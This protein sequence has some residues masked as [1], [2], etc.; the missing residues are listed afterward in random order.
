MGGS[1][2]I[3][4][5]VAGFVGILIG[6]WMGPDVDDARDEIVSRVDEV[7]GTLGRIDEKVATLGAP[8]ADTGTAQAIAD[9]GAKIDAVDASVKAEAAAPAPAP[10]APASDPQVVAKLDALAA[11]LQAMQAAA[12]AP[13]PAPAAAAPAGGDVAALVG[14]VGSGGAILVPGQSAIFGGSTVTLSALSAT[15]ATLGTGGAAG[16]EV[17]TGSSLEVGTG[18]SVTLAGVAQGLAFLKPEG[19]GAAASASTPAAAPAAPPAAAAPAAAPAAPAAGGTV[20][21]VGIGQTASFG[22]TR[23]F[24]SGV[25]QNGV[26]LFPAGGKA[27]NRKTVETGATYDA[28]NGCTVKVDSVAD[29]VATLS[30]TGCGAA[31]ADA[32]PSEGAAPA[33]AAAP[34][35]APAAPAA[36]PAAP[37]AAPAPAAPAAPAAAPAAAA[38]AGGNGGTIETGQTLKLGEK[39]VFL[40]GVADN[41]AT[42]YVVGAGRQTI[43]SGASA[44]V[45][46]GCMVKLDGIEGRAA[47]LSATGC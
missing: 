43:E 10:A 31:A 32:A 15:G 13:A 33:Q 27:G 12:P 2:F 34:A 37:A 26:T 18:C 35:A 1:K 22:E 29:G 6:W 5:I 24:V 23:L 21:T 8:P 19:C 17:A 3:P 47:T 45:G 39:T 28:G 9:L 30:S 41:A 36:A 4:L 40:S 20:A 46:G 42:I 16:S 7:R 25:S 11:Q 14:T 44:D 38:P